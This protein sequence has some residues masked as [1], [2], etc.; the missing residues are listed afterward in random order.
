MVVPSARPRVLRACVP[1][2]RGPRIIPLLQMRKWLTCLRPAS[3]NLPVLT[4]G[5][6]TPGR[7]P[8]N[9]KLSPRQRLPFSAG[10]ARGRVRLAGAP[11][12][13][14]FPCRPPLNA[15]PPFHVTAA[16]A[17]QVLGAAP[18]EPSSRA[19][20]PWG[21][22][23]RPAAHARPPLLPPG[24]GLEPDAPGLRPP[25]TR[26]GAA[27]VTPQGLTARPRPERPLTARCLGAGSASR[28]P[29]TPPA[30]APPTSPGLVQEAAVA[31]PLA[32]VPPTN[33]DPFHQSSASTGRLMSP[34]SDTRP[35][36]P[37]LELAS[38]RPSGA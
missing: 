23:P 13:P 1:D 33:P 10:L 30:R 15:T 18:P 3:G 27:P 20:L 22:R 9:P 12:S 11:Q 34:A 2:D 16:Y 24:S 25:S 36:I 7:P 28:V 6:G 37:D 35:P 31:P 14:G 26:P 32:T 8:R 21:L 17:D 19:R 38:L 29:V 4:P 5:P